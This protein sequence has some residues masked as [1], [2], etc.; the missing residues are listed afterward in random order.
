MRL[1]YFLL[2]G[3]LL[4]LPARAQTV[5]ALPATDQVR[6]EAIYRL[7]FRTDSTA[8]ATRSDIMRLQIGSKMSRFESLNAVRGDSLVESAFKTA[9]TQATGSGSNKTIDMGK[10]DIGAFRTSFREI[11]FK[12]PAAKQLVFRDRIGL[13]KFAYA[14]PLDR[15]AWTILPT[16]AAIA[17]YNCQRATTT[18]AGRH[19]EA[20]FTREVP[21]P[22]GPY[23]FYGLPGLIVKLA[24]TGASYTYELARL[25]QLPAPVPMKVP[26]ENAKSVSKAEFL[27]GKATDARAGL[28]QMLANG[29]IRFKTPEEETAFRQKARERAK[30]PTNPIELK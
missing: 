15:L 11:I 24:D 2:A 29:N 30:R 1:R 10:I 8:P 22:E 26:E 23:K 6:L 28:E 20:W 27:A 9:E 5:P 14:E 16:T 3:A 25:R 18:Y 7:T 13:G 17:G 4:A 21:V 19:W 12:I